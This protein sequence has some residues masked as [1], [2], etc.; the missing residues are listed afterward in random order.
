MAYLF[1]IF[2]RSVLREKIGLD[3]VLTI[4]LLY[5]ESFHGSIRQDVK[6]FIYLWL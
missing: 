6:T 5:D 1:R 4:I 2:C 3:D